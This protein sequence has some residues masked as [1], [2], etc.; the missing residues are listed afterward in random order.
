MARHVKTLFRIP[1][2]NHQKSNMASAIQ[3]QLAK[4]E[5]PPRMFCKLDITYNDFQAISHDSSPRGYPTRFY[6]SPSAFGAQSKFSTSLGAKC[7]SIW[8]LGVREIHVLFF[9]IN[10]YTVV[11]NSGFIMF[12]NVVTSKYSDSKY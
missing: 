11:F 5:N 7:T 10:Q 3:Y 2:K 12:N 4:W 9:H 1:S 8:W 6:S